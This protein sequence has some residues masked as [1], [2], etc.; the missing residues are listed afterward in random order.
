[1]MNC[2]PANDPRNSNI[3]KSERLSF[4]PCL[5]LQIRLLKLC[6]A[7]AR[8]FS[9]VNFWTCDFGCLLNMF[10]RSLSKQNVIITIAVLC[11]QPIISYLSQQMEK[12]HLI[13]VS[14]YQYW[15]SGLIR[16]IDCVASVMVLLFG[17]SWTCPSVLV[18]VHSDLWLILSASRHSGPH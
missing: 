10:S 11:P 5:T 16:F 7:S 13:K 3:Y 12:K 4:L 15:F 6:D 9:S 1:M 8:T 17:C 18:F 2:Q 14:Q